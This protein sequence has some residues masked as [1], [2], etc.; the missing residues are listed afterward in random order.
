MPTH[1][2][3]RTA[4]REHGKDLAYA[5]GW[6][7][8]RKMPEPVARRLFQRAADQ[9]WRRQGKSVR[10]L[11]ANLA[12]VAPTADLDVLTRQ[13]IRSYARYWLEVFRLPDMSAERVVGNMYVRDEERIFEA[14]ARGKGV[15]LALPHMGNWDHAGAWLVHRGI[16]FTTVA[17]RLQPDSLFDRFV[18]FRESLGMEVIALAG[19]GGAAGGAARDAPQAPFDLLAE[20]LEAGRMLCLLSERDLTRNGVPVTF[21]GETATMPAGPAALCLRTGATLLPTTVWFTP[22]GWEGQIHP[23]VAHTDIATMTQTMADNFAAMI[24]AHPQDWHMFQRLWRA[25]LD[26]RSTL[27]A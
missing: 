25:D 10:R 27:P 3:A 19:E 23:S 15:I 7:A 21:F 17:E 20:R 2:S 14:H 8:V 24:A 11:R 4:V 6:G 1:R 9:A 22:N 5:L 16:P 13:G 12:R 18:E 26:T